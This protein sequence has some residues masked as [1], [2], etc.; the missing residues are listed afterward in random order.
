MK[1]K[2][3]YGWKMFPA[4]WLIYFLGCGPVT[5]GTSV[6]ITKMVRTYSWN[7]SI[8][9]YSTS[10]YQLT[11]ALMS[12]A[13]VFFIR[14]FSHKAAMI[15]GS[16]VGAAVYFFMAFGNLS[17]VHV[18]IALAAAGFCNAFTCLTPCPGLINN[19]FDRRKSVPMSFVL[20]AGAASGFIMPLLAQALSSRSIS[21]CW[22][23][24]A[25]MVLAIAVLAVLFVKERPEDIGEV[26]DGRAW[27]EANPLPEKAASEM[28]EKEPS[29]KACYA[30]RAF[31]VIVFSMCAFRALQLMYTTYAVLYG[32]QNGLTEVQ[33]A[34]LLTIGN[35]FGLGGRLFAGVA[36]Q[37]KMAYHKILVIGL[38]VITAGGA[39]FAAGHSFGILV[40]AAIVL[41]GANGFLQSFLPIAVP[42]YF[43]SGN[44]S[45]VYGM[46]NTVG[47]ILGCAAPL[48]VIWIVKVFGS[49]SYGFIFFG[50]LTAIAAVL[51]LFTPAQFVTDKKTEGKTECVQSN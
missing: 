36:G 46:L 30:S 31:A 51:M 15:V 26:K 35:I 14:R 17:P 29:L 43:G 8:L 24:Y 40:A 47:G 41:G 44:F 25:V 18:I 20:A 39:L 2:I 21:F 28:K 19:W 34:L 27:V 4:V 50:V 37:M 32:L 49:Y 22:L 16:V 38:V 13:V 9:G 48:L 1:K 23:V 11:M 5:Y 10:I 3:F 45:A 42:K 12:F 33:A 6:L 7:E